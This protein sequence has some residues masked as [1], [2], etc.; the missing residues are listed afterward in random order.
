MRTLAK[1]FLGFAVA[2]FA[3]CQHTY[4]ELPV[5]GVPALPKLKADTM[6]YVAIPPDARFKK[7][8]IQNSGQT[9]SVVVR[10]AFAKYVKR[11]YVGRRAQTFAEGLETAREVQCA[12]FVYPSILVWEDHATDLSGRRDKLEIKIQ[13]ADSATGEVL[14]ATILSGRSR[15]FND[16]GDTPQDLLP[17][18]VKNYVASLFQ[19]VYTPSALR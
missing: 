3:G 8:L 13:V 9:T 10:D 14:H 7:E 18:P 1:I 12:Y 6:V 5:A 17:E 11:A 4:K 19:P 2:L 15:W 16:G